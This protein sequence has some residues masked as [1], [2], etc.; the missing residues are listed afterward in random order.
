MEWQHPSFS[1]H[2]GGSEKYRTEH[3]RIFGPKDNE[4]TPV[5]D[6]EDKL[7][8]DQ[9]LALQ[10]RIQQL[11]S[12]VDRLNDNV[13]LAVAQITSGDQYIQH[14]IWTKTGKCEF[15]NSKKPNHSKK[16]KTQTRRNE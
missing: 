7:E 1:V 13:A 3:E 11:E 4:T 2:L 10:V 15:C 14:I 12:E 9:N 5:K 8:I 6:I 16:C